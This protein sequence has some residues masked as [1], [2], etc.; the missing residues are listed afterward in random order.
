[1]VAPEYLG[2]LQRRIPVPDTCVSK[3]NTIPCDSS[4]ISRKVL[5]EQLVFLKEIQFLVIP[6]LYPEKY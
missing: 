4:I 5:G 1:M 2:V 3:R 6:L